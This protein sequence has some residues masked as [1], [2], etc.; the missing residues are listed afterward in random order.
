[1]AQLI[2]EAGFPPGVINVLSGLG[3]TTGAALVAHP[4]VN[5]IS[6]TGSKVVGQTIQ[7]AAAADCKRVTLELGGKS[8]VIVFKDADLD[9]AVETCHNGL[10]WNEGEACAAAT[11]ILV[12]DEI[13]D[14]FCRR[15]AEMAAKRRVGNPFADY[16][17]SGGDAGADGKGKVAQG[18]L[19][20][21]AQLH[22]VL[23]YIESLKADGAT[24]L[25]GGER[26]G[27]VGAFVQPTV[28]ADV[29]DNMQGWR[30][31]IFGPVMTIGR[32][33]RKDGFANDAAGVTD[34]LRRA[35]DSEYGLASAVF[36]NDHKLGQQCLSKLRCGLVFWNCYH[37]VDISAPFG[38]YKQ[39]GF[40]REGGE[41]GLL[42]YLEVKNCAI[43]IT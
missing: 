11:R 25:A 27:T 3:S 22:K 8:P 23:G 6:F 4:E 40:G 2:V 5:K 19:V 28:F 15:S 30:E 39:S 21:D 16:D 33:S 24:L 9:A 35:N 14:E 37:V 43:K 18:S 17:A 29:T 31:E 32:F 13:Y 7:A 26:I 38:G 41:Y 20:S 36:T 10:F 1:L 34:V 42:P 12:E